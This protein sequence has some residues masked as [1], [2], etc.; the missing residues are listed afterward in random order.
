VTSTT[1]RRGHREREKTGGKTGDKEK[2]I[3]QLDKDRAAFIHKS[4]PFSS[5]FLLLLL[6]LLRVE[7]SQAT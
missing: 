6:L 4:S 2:K 1:N 7:R 5:I 3:M